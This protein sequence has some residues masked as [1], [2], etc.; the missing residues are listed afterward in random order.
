LFKRREYRYLSLSFDLTTIPQV[1]K[2]TIHRVVLPQATTPGGLTPQRNS[3]AFFSNFNLDLTIETLPGC[4][5]AKY[6]PVK[7]G[8]YL[9]RRLAEMFG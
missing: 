1:L 4:G 8:E 5:D 9:E 2:S 7:C 6:E 3:I